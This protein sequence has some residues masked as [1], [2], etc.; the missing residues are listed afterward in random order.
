MKT[1]R[2]TTAA[3]TTQESS[4]FSK[5]GEQDFFGASTGENDFFP[6]QTKLNIGEPNDIYEKEAEQTADKIVGCPSTTALSKDISSINRHSSAQRKPIFESDA[7]FAPGADTLQTKPQPSQSPPTPGPSVEAGL[8]GSKGQG[9]PIAP[10]IRSS[11]NRSFGSDFNDV[12]IHTDNKAADMSREINA[13]AFTHGKD[14]YF[15]AG[16]FDPNSNQGKHL[17][18]HELTHTIQ[19]GSTPKNIQR[20]PGDAATDKKMTVEEVAKN[21]PSPVGEI[22][23]KDGKTAIKISKLKVKEN[24]PK[25]LLDKLPRPLTLPRSG[26]RNTKENATNQVGIWK[27]KVREN[28]AASV[29]SLLQGINQSQNLASK[30]APAN[31][32]TLQLKDGKGIA[33]IVGNATEIQNGALVSKWNKAGTTTAFQVEHILDYQ[34][35]GKSADTIENLMLLSAAVN[36]NLGQLMKQFIRGDIQTILTHY[37]ERVAPGTLVTSADAAREDVNYDIKAQEFEKVPTDVK[38][39]QEILRE[40]LKN[41]TEDPLRKN[42]V[43][44]ES[45]SIKD[46]HFILKSNKTGG[47]VVLPYATKNFNLG[48]YIITTNGDPVAG[49]ISQLVA[50]QVIAGSHTEEQPQP[51]TFEL[52]VV[53]GKLHEFKASG[54]GSHMAALKLKYLSPINFTEPEVDD[55]YNL[56][57]YGTIAAPSPSFLNNTPIEVI[58]SGRD[59]QI[60]KT[61]SASNLTSVGPIK[62]DNASVMLGLSTA[63]G[64]SASGIVEFSIPKI[65]KG[66]VSA[67][68]IENGFTLSGHFDFDSKMFDKARIKVVYNSVL[69]SQKKSAWTIEGQID[70]SNEKIKGITKA[71]INVLYKDNALTLKGNADLNIPGVKSASIDA[72]YSGGAFSFNLTTQFDFKNKFLQNPMLTVSM[73]SGGEGAPDGITL[74][75]E[76]NV[77]IVIPNFKTA[78]LVVKYLS[79]K[80]D[81]SVS[82]TDL[83]VGNYITGEITLGATN[84]VVDEANGTAAGEGKGKQLTLY[85]SG[86]VTIKLGENINSKIGLKL[87]KEGKIL[88]NGEFKVDKQPLWSG[89]PLLQF[90]Y[91][92]FEFRTPGVPIFTIGVADISLSI[93]A[94]AE[95]MAKVDIPVVSILVNLKDTDIFDPAGFVI[96]TAVKPEIG[97][98]AGVDLD[99]KFI[100]AA[101]VLIA[102]V[103]ANIGGKLMLH[104]NT[105]ADA[106]LNM[107]WSSKKG[108]RFKPGEGNLD[109]D[110]TVTGAITGGLSVDLNLF[111]TRINVWKKDWILAQTN[112][113]SLGKMGLKFP[114]NFDDAGKIKTPDTKAPPPTSDYSSEAGATSFLKKQAGADEKVEKKPEDFKANFLKI[115]Q[116]LPALGP[117]SPRYAAERSRHFF[118]GEIE[119]AYPQSDWTWLRTEWTSMETSEFFRLADQLR[120]PKGNAGAKLKK[121]DDFAFNHPAVNGKE[122]E[123]LKDEINL[124]H[125]TGTKVQKTALPDAGSPSPVADAN[126]GNDSTESS[127]DRSRGNGKPIPQGLRNNLESSFDKDFSAVRLHDDAASRKMNSDLR[128]KAFAS[129]KDIYFGATANDPH[130]HAGMHLLAHEL[131]HVV[132][133]SASNGDAAVPD[134][135]RHPVAQTEVK[136]KTNIDLFGDGTALHPGEELD[137][138][139]KYTRKQADWFAEPTLA[140][141]D[142]TDLWN[143]LF[144]SSKSSDATGGANGLKLQ[145]IRSLSAADWSLLKA[146][147]RAC[148]S[149]SPTVRVE[150]ATAYT[151]PQRLSLGKTL[152]ALE[153]IIPPDVLEQTVGEIQLKDIDAKPSLISG[154]WLYFTLFRPHL[155]RKDTA[156][157]AGKRN[158]EFQAILDLLNTAFGIAP[159]FS[160]IGRVRNLHRFTIK[161]LDRLVINYTDTSH[162]KPL[163]LVLHS[164]H[165]EAGSFAGDQPLLEALVLHPDTL[166]L[167]IEGAGTLAGITAQIPILASTYGKPD[168]KGIRRI[169]RVMIS[170]HGET[171]SVQLAGTGAPVVSG[172]TVEYHT[173]SLNLD[174]P[175]AAKATENLIDAL[176]KNMDPATAKIVFNGCLVGSNI[177]PPG[178]P[179]ADI[180]KYLAANPNLKTFTENRA[181]MLKLGL[182]V[183]IVQGPRASIGVP[184]TLMDAKG[185]LELKYSYDPDAYGTSAAYIATGN[186]P[187]GVMRAAIELAA[188]DP[189]AAATQ[190][191]ARKLK[192]AAAGD[193]W[194][195]IVVAFVDM[196]L[197]GVPAGGPVNLATLHTLSAMV[198]TVFLV[199]WPSFGIKVGHFVSIVNTQPLL[200]KTVYA[201]IAATRSFN[202]PPD[203]D[204]EDMRMIVEQGRIL[205]GEAREANLISFINSTVPISRIENALDVLNLMGKDAAFFPLGGLSSGKVRLAIAWLLQDPS[206]PDVVKFLDNEVV[207]DPSGPTFSALI[208]TELATAGIEEETILGMLGR[209]ESKE[210]T[211]GKDGKVKEKDKANSEITGDTKNDA[212]VKILPYVATVSPKIYALNVRKRPSISGKPFAWLKPGDKVNVMGF[213]HDWAAIDQNGKLGFVYRTKISPP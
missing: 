155:Q 35:A 117:G 113:G 160:L 76:G 11:M 193:W 79:G 174:D 154:L 158:I 159:Y 130:T 171:R 67:A 140:P 126:G 73:S 20:E 175:A 66:S 129:G 38:P 43:K 88:I 103:S 179:T 71:T 135:S 74:G 195:E 100:I 170:G 133:Q 120:Q 12:R 191:R 69:D 119:K 30:K 39:E 90:R 156:A 42:L 47:G 54:F 181:A 177:I 57:A 176:L 37:N 75:V 18:A 41:A 127:L 13:Q 2:T 26:S 15:N 110:I 180:P 201:K 173:E 138:F 111:F 61:F 62:I 19:Q 112:L 93:Q 95:A 161:T 31:R 148:N 107:E 168:A 27:S 51:E 185:N 36:N 94:S 22:S 205:S 106:T 187:D 118:I 211:I 82:I 29:D 182:P 23:T 165:D 70:T 169:S 123:T 16:K 134:I 105:N 186:E 86:S 85:G 183:D 116:G 142:R 104:I 50:Q 209:L 91:T 72:T 139:E 131:T 210:K 157:G 164:P 121:L 197:D 55:Y 87:N 151:L 189:V 1:V 125:K 153:A 132:Q 32:Y 4:P 89:D 144:L 137:D 21:S 78:K 40:D 152:L 124:L 196:A 194:Q 192:G 96:N 141:A 60:Q 204:A 58:L 149:T 102:E 178:T 5:K 44:F 14:I 59:L 46:G 84:A 143:L 68:T 56:T 24:A 184:D 172:D 115:L 188:T 17:L 28:V 203:T 122:I 49:T 146:F 65:G 162:K 147:G 145:E 166:V 8:N 163:Q 80:F 77:D 81:A 64:F 83:R 33:V 63:T 150:S 108:L 207:D 92:I 109:A 6:V 53:P 48:S 208:K 9:S 97:A 34:I 3:Q 198:N 128:S 98:V 52:T 190:L 25:S 10:D 206:A 202:T 45:F 114:I 136:R 200:T 199:R 7:E 101:S 99:A 212:Y 213:V 167:M